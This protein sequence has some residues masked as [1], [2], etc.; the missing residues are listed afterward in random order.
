MADS[1]NPSG[2]LH[3]DITDRHRLGRIKGDWEDAMMGEIPEANERAWNQGA[4][5]V[6]DGQVDS[7][8]EVKAVGDWYRRKVA[9]ASQSEAAPVEETPQE[10]IDAREEWE[11]Y[12][13][14]RGEGSI[15]YDP[16]SGKRGA[17]I[18]DGVGAAA[19]YGNRATDDFHNRFVPHLYATANLQAQEMGHAG[20]QHLDRFEGNVPD[21]KSDDIKDVYG[22]YSDKITNTGKYA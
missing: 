7:H 11:A 15:H 5:E 19:D 22:Y 17:G 1:H 20:G 13:A 8:A 2:S 6:T 12:E 9:E 21:L 14:R 10:L 18:V 16:T 3:F 4:E